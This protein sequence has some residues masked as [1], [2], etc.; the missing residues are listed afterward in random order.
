MIQFFISKI[1][2]YCLDTQCDPF[3]W[4]RK[5]LE[6]CFEVFTEKK[7]LKSVCLSCARNC[8]S[9]YRLRPYVR[10]RSSKDICECRTSGLCQCSWSLIRAEF[11][12]LAEEDKC[13]GP[14]QLRDLLKLL[15]QPYPV[16]A[17]DM[18]SCVL[19]LS[20]GKEEGRLPRIH[21][22]KFEKWYRKHF[23]EKDEN[24]I[25]DED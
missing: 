22:V 7:H 9:S 4:R 2:R 18:E 3:D 5:A 1:Y 6:A 21:P 17:G 25:E 12:K 13:I 8:L 10:N 24:T 23:D 19:A 11:D 15:R 16:E 14:F 20:D